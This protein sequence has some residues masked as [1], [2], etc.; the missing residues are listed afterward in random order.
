[1]RFTGSVPEGY[2]VVEEPAPAIGACSISKR[3]PNRLQ[4]ACARISEACILV[5]SRKSDLFPPVSNASFRLPRSF[6]EIAV[7]SDRQSTIR[8]SSRIHGM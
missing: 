7:V 8:R 6:I 1:V 3:S 2:R 4:K 5:M